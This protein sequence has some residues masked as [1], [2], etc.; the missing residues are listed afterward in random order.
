MADVIVEV[1]EVLAR[2]SEGRGEVRVRADHVAAALEALFGVHPELRP[3]VLDARGRVHPYLVLFRDGEELP[4]AGLAAFALRDGSRVELVGAAEGG[5]AAAAGAADDDVRMRGF[6]T[7]VALEDAVAEALSGLVPLGAES[8]HVADA[9]GRVL[10]ADV[11]SGVDVPAF[12]RAAMDGYAVH[13]E[14]TFGA[15]PYAPRALRLVGEQMPGA[16]GDTVLAA[17]TACRIMTGA[18]LPAGADAVLPA[19]CAREGAESVEAVDVVTP[20]RNVGR[21]GED[22]RRGDALLARGRRLRPQDVGLLASVGA[23][24]VAVVARPRVR[25]LVTGNELLPPGATP[26]GDRIVDS[27]TPMLAALV[28]RDGGVV[29]ES[30]RLRDDAAAIRA[31]LAAPGADVIVAAG[32]TS[33]G[34]ED[35]LPLLVRELGALPVHG[36][37]VRPAAPSGIGRIGGTPVFLLPGN[38]VACLCAYDLFAGPAIRTLAGLPAAWP[39]GCA[40]LPLSERIASQLGRSDYV[41]VRL[42]AGGVVPIAASG[43]SVL[44]STTRADGFV[45]VPASSE[46]LPAGATVAVHFYDAWTLGS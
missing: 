42:A 44:S 5:C 46:G 21:V 10:A 41:R 45:L 30:L 27:N 28:A 16:G 36:V 24:P 31:A 4:R 22:V 15:T 20:G 38:P 18:A 13:A 14:D 8:V 29:A 6:R 25:L 19:E 1:P 40:E 32:G 9:A 23:S 3:R 39:Y 26:S 17:G 7:R 2:Y 35:F 33:V 37:A 11:A 12:P 34:R 43:A